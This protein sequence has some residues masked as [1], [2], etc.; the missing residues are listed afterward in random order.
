M[1]AKGFLTR[2][3]KEV[4]DFI[5]AFVKKEGYGPSLKE[6][7]EAMGFTSHSTAQFHVNQLAE[8]GFLKKSSGS[9]RGIELLKRD[10]VVE[11]PILGLVPAGGSMEALEEAEPEIK[12]IPKS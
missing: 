10:E 5:Q 4:L 6:I 2:K 8:K 9:V 7:K 11:V 12:K 3:Q 1:V